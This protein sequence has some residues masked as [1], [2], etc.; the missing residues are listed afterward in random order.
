MDA[1][2][3]AAAA[4]RGL[5]ARA[6]QREGEARLTRTGRVATLAIR[7]P[8]ARNA[9]T[10]D[11]MAA[12]ADAVAALGAWD[13]GALLVVT[14][15]D[16]RAFC[17]G[18][19]LEQVVAAVDGPQAAA[20]MCRAMR[21]T[22]SALLALPLVS[23][24]HVEGVA[25]GGGAELATATD[26]RVFG[27]D[28]RLRFVQARLGIA[29][30]WGGVERLVGLVGRSNALRIAGTAPWID[31]ATA[32]SIG[33]AEPDASLTDWLARWDEIPTGAIRAAKAQV[34]AAV[35]GDAE[36]DVAAFA[37]VWGGPDHRAALAG[38]TGRTR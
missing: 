33:L 25:L 20:V 9:L 26:A 13:E 21:V 29:S 4:L 2:T 7:H 35:R 10:L 32:R 17:S 36:A 31:G 6:P 1:L 8:A 3:E 28:A 30:G 22:L 19:D 15:S 27:P 18:G 5:A 37:G 23:V 24:A 11:M 34:A 12:I 38:R 16:P 14:S